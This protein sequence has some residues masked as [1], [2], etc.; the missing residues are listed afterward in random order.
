MSEG[1]GC[2]DKICPCKVTR[3]RIVMTVMA[4][5]CFLLTAWTVV[6]T[7][8]AKGSAPQNVSLVFIDDSKSVDNLNIT[9]SSKVLTLT[10]LFG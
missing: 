3:K 5:C 10:Y 8:Q 6:I 4:I 2:C 1:S 7:G 9:L